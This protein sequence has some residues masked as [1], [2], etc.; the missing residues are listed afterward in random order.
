MKKKGFTLI[1]LLA[2]IIIL[3]ILMIIA[4]PNISRYIDNSRKSAYVA[5]IKEIVQGAG[6]LLTNKHMNDLDRETTYYIPNNC[7]KGEKGIARSPYNEF[8][9]AYIVAGWD[10]GG[11]GIYWLGRDKSGIGIKNPKKCCHSVIICA[12]IR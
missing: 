5:T 7:I 10:S 2:V 4:V 8:D 3:G 1:E 9:Q 12:Y 11:F 6:S